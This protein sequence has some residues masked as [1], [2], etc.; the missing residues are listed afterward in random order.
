MMFHHFRHLETKLK[1][2]HLST[3]EGRSLW[4]FV[5]F[6]IVQ[7]S[8]EQR[9][10]NYLDQETNASPD[11]VSNTR[12]KVFVNK[13][14]HVINLDINRL[15]RPLIVLLLSSKIIEW[16]P[17]PECCTNK[18]KIFSS[19]S[20]RTTFSFFL[21]HKQTQIKRKLKSLTLALCNFFH[22]LDCMEELNFIQYDWLNSKIV[23]FHWA[24]TIVILCKTHSGSY[25]HP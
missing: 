19:I 21:I 20:C 18:L 7:F 23:H 4:F 1:S 16:A 14:Y 17:F 15:L 3:A 25:W 6:L 13:K 2:Q 22:N 11:Q 12:R 9:E 24:P 10:E 5:L 8:V